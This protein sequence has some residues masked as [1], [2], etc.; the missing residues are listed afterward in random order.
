[1]SPQP[2][3]AASGAIDAGSQKK[4]RDAAVEFEG[5]LLAEMLRS[6]REAEQSEEEDGAGSTM[7]DLADQHF[8]KVLASQGGLGLAKLV[9]RDLPR[10]EPG[11]GPSSS[12]R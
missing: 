3:S 1:M 9:L 11:P 4:L 5:M 12:A 10:S 2:I 8:A 6:V 7:L